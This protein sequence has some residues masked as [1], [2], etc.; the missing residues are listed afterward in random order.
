MLR[1][2]YHSSALIKV[3]FIQ[4]LF[5]FFHFTFLAVLG[6]LCC[7]G[8]SLVV[9]SRGL[10]LVVMQKLFTVVV[11]PITYTLEYEL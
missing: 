11:S 4:F 9:A 5:F 2:C 10:S 3:G 7:A 8:L 1:K 6:L